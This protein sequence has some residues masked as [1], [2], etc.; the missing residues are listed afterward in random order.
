[1]VNIEG[2]TNVPYVTIPL[3]GENLWRYTIQVHITAGQGVALNSVVCAEHVNASAMWLEHH[4]LL[5]QC[6]VC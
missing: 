4:M 3:G 6:C 2:L 5:D 1:M